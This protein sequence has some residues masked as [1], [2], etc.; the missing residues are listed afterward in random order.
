MKAVFLDFATVG[1]DELDISPLATLLPDLQV[2]DSTPSADVVR[3]IG[4]AEFVFANKTQ[5]TREVF[6]A[7]PSLKFIGLVATG[8]DNVDLEAAAEQGVAVCNIRGYCTQSV[9]EHV[10][11]VLLHH[12]HNIGRYHASVRAGN[13]QKAENFCMI[14][15]PI[16]E[17]SAMTLGIVGHGEL[18]RGVERIARQ[19]N[20]QVLIS[21]RPGQEVTPGSGRTRFTDVLRQCDV[22]TLHCPL[23]IDTRGMISAT[24]LKSMRADAILIN[25]ARGA[26]VDGA[27]LVDAL[28]DGTIAAAAIDVLSAEPPVN[29]DPLLNYDGDNLIITPHVAWATKE[30]R[31]NAINE[32]AA[33]VAAFIAGEERNR[34]V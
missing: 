3:C 26:L 16:R 29:G 19:F 30:A 5:L 18:G 4:D 21:A 10:F 28:R 15:Y 2:L 7:A 6:A 8:V 14:E 12:A 20:M 27:A 31:Q 11:G 25:T 9:V 23:T 24:E 32:L 13:W 33:N 1:P 22:I 17:L 34:I